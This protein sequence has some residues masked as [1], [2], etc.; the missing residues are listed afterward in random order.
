MV[1]SDFGLA[2]EAH[3]HNG[4]HSHREGK[5]RE[6]QAECDHLPLVV[7]ELSM[8]DSTCDQLGG[9][10]A[11]EQR[12]KKQPQDFTRNRNMSFTDI[13]FAMV[14]MVNAS[15]QTML[16]RHFPQLK[17]ENLHMTQQA[18]SKARRKIKGE[19]FEEALQATV[20]GSYHELC[21]WWRGFRVMRIDGSCITLPA[22]PALKAHFGALGAEGTLPAALGSIRYD[23]ANDVMLDAKLVPIRERER[24]LALEPLKAL[25]GLERFKAGHWELVIVDR[26]Y[27][28]DECIGQ[29]AGYGIN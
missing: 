24:T 27:L 14:R 11:Y 5:Q 26:G 1:G 20:K 18:F 2:A 6:L 23:L 21:V 17:K 3:G 19:A 16:E 10:K 29:I 9:A 15:S 13:L 8:A 25:T 7:D 28:S 12:S 4:V 22:S